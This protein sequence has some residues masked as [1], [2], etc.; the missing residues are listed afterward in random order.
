MNIHVFKH[1]HVWQLFLKYLFVLETLKCTG[2]FQA[3]IF[4]FCL[5]LSHLW[6]L[7]LAFENTLLTLSSPLGSNL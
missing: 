4:F 3:S 1:F 7:L 5:E 6:G 2:T